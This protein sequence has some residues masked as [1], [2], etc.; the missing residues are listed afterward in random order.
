MLELDKYIPKY[1][2][3]ETIKALK[4]I[5]DGEKIPKSGAVEVLHHMINYPGENFFL[6]TDKRIRFFYYDYEDFIMTIKDQEPGWAIDVSQNIL[7]IVLLFKEEDNLVPIS[8]NFDISKDLYRNALKLLFKKKGLRLTMLSI[9]CG[10]LIVDSKHYYSMPAH[11]R[12][13]LKGI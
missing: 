11:I 12:E 4:S 7:K 13:A 8:F 9:D 1:D 6:S 5:K 3:K 10:Q 2:N